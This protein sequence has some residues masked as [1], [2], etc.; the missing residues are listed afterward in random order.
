[1]FAP[2]PAL[3]QS[4][5]LTKARDYAAYM[6]VMELKANTSNNTD[7]CRFR[8]SHRLSPP[9]IHP[10]SRRPFRL[11][12][13][14]RRRRPPHRL[15]RP[16]RARPT[17]LILLD[18]STGWIEN[19]NNWPYTAAGAASP[20]QAD[21]PRYMDTAGD[22]MRGLHAVKLLTGKHDFTLPS[23]ISAA[24]DPWSSPA[25]TSSSPTC[26]TPT[27]TS[28]PTDPLAYKSLP[29]QI[30]LL[31]TWDRRWSAESIPTTLAVLWGETLWRFTDQTAPCQHHRYVYDTVLRCATA[32][33]N[34]E[35]HLSN[36]SDQLTA[37]FGTWRQ[38]WGNINRIQRLTDDIVPAYSDTCPE[39][40]RCPSPPPNGARSPPSPVRHQ[41][42]IKKAL[43][44]Q[45]QQ[46]RRCHR[47][48]PAHKSRRGDRRRRK[49]RSCVKTFQRRGSAA[50][51]HGQPEEMSISIPMR[52]SQHTERRY[53]PGE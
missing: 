50:L 46:L 37:D 25:S 2:I 6:K 27:T 51:R 34:A 35:R 45:R 15:A 30:T 43:R 20:K 3:E 38:P 9:P 32:G 13:T 4:Y 26:S 18:P 41:P 40:A 29:D 17:R 14:R 49:R 42:G 39:H 53:H 19:T 22:N 8:R 44:Q 10:P 16:A 33:R 36:A 11:H 5:G 52:S 1:M 48:W 28:R 31:R 23:L 12:Q 24:Y 21:Y 7:L 47:I